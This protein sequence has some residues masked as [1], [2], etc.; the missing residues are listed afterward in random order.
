MHI[1]IWISGSPSNLGSNEGLL[2]LFSFFL[3]PLL[4]ED[5]TVTCL[6][7]KGGDIALMAWASELNLGENP[8]LDFKA[9]DL[10]WDHPSELDIRAQMAIELGV[11]VW[12]VIRV[13]H[14]R[15][16][17]VPAP[18]CAFFADFLLLDYPF[19]FP[20]EVYYDLY[21]QTRDLAPQYDRLISFSNYVA[22][23]HGVKGLK[24][25]AEKIKVVPH[26]PLDYLE[27]NAKFLE[28]ELGYTPANFA[29]LKRSDAADILRGW[30]GSSESM[31]L[32]AAMAL[33]L[34]SYMANYPYEEVDFV[35]CSTM[36]RPHKNVSTLLNSVV[37]V[38]NEYAPLK[39]ILSAPVDTASVEPV[40]ALIRKTRSHIDVLSINHTPNHIH[41]CLYRLAAVT[42]HPS[43]FEGGFPFTFSESLSMGTPIILARGPAVNEF[44]TDEEIEAYCFE[45]SSSEDLQKRIKYV[46][47]NRDSYLAM[48][49]KTL[50]R[51]K[52][53]R[54]WTDVAREY[55]E[56]FQEAKDSF[57]RRPVDF[58][59]RLLLAKTGS[60]SGDIFLPTGEAGTYLED[61][62]A[63]CE[64]YMP[65]SFVGT[66]EVDLIFDSLPQT[67]NEVLVGRSCVWTEHDLQ[68]YPDSHPVLLEPD[69][70]GS[71]RVK[72]RFIYPAV[73]EGAV[74]EVRIYW[75]GG[76][77]AR[78]RK[79]EWRA[80]NV[81]G[82]VLVASDRGLLPSLFSR[83]MKLCLPRPL[84]A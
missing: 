66:F 44:L 20:R 78:L 29:D 16:E 11:D 60:Q 43:P 45:P 5:V 56:V 62:S 64:R 1:G 74:K 76:A 18:W 41:A 67:L 48:Q 46:L 36:N 24:L 55:L 8:N 72:F 59:T 34:R 31:Y 63:I 30:L 54:N 13:D 40:G 81:P 2:R 50:E 39:L 84:Q 57:W 6:T 17:L 52:R 73:D 77:K 69:A 12:T 28:K 79:V 71:H 25:P 58:E 23:A 53:A 32:D 14:V 26:A 42:V 3:G 22:L 10:E 7:P 82:Q 35:F 75:L 33:Q 37:D 61:L 70:D 80:H 21:N 9:T 47:A 51:Q 83:A 65:K 49:L 27:Y 38:R 68:F 15:P 19:L 4:D